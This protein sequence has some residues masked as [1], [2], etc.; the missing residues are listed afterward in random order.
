MNLYDLTVPQLI[1]M[2]KNVDNWLAAAT[3]HAEEMKNGLP[4]RYHFMCAYCS[5]GL[6]PP[7]IWISALIERGYSYMRRNVNRL[8]VVSHSRNRTS[9]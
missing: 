8:F 6:R 4:T 5:G 1:K 9:C 2:L 3:K 7:I